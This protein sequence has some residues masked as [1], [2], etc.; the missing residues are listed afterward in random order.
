[1]EIGQRAGGPGVGGRLL[2]GGGGGKGGR[3]G[4]ALAETLASTFLS[5]QLCASKET[6]RGTGRNK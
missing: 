1:M 3:G 5:W 2:Q 4:S 6:R